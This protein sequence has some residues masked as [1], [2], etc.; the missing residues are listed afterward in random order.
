[1][2]RLGVPSAAYESGAFS[3]GFIEGYNTMDALA[4]SCFRYCHFIGRATKG[5]TDRKQLTRYTMKAGI[6]AGILLSLVYISQA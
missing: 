5:I 6:I 4:R 3:K 1:M 2:P